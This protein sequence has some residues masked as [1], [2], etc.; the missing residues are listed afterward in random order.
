MW[1]ACLIYVAYNAVMF[2]F[3]AHFNAYFL[4]YTT[5][6]ALSFWA[7]VTL[8]RVAPVE[9]FGA[10][11]AR[12]P[13]RAVAVYLLLSLAFF[14]ALWLQAIV[15]AMLTASMPPAIVEMGWPSAPRGSGGD[16]PGVSCWAAG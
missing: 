13:A 8:L 7:L 2:C 1:F 16:G 11:G 14:A 15:P 12:V 10:A 3:A 5:M 6:L 9:T 4:L